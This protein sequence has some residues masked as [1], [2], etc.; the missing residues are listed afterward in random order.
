MIKTKPTQ[1]TTMITLKSYISKYAWHSRSQQCLP[2]SI[3]RHL[4]AKEVQITVNTHPE[5]VNIINSFTEYCPHTHTH[6]HTHTCTHVHTSTHILSL[7]LRTPMSSL[8]LTDACICWLGRITKKHISASLTTNTILKIRRN[9]NTSDFHNIT[10]TVF[11]WLLATC[12]RHWHT[13]NIWL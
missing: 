12:T 4:H 3:L 10:C 8:Q 2:A 9:T 6:T 7:F 13:V 11:W 5:Y 1:Y